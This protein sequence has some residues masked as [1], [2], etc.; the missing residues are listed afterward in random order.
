M[1]AAVL[2]AAPLA[3]N[4]QTPGGDQLPRFAS[5]RSDEINLRV[6]PGENY[7]IEWVYRRKDLPVEIIEEFQ[8]WRRIEDWQGTKGWVLDRMLIDKREVIV[9]GAVQPLHGRPDTAAPIIARAEPGV[10]ARLLA[11]GGAWC[12][13]EAAGYSGWVKR[14]EIW[15]VL[16]DETVQ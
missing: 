6:G 9:D 12:R 7:P 16:P 4:A 14:S 15:G 1:A 3:L 10:V 13:I 8:N 11:C 2:A 5:L